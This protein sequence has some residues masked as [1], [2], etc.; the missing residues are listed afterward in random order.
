MFKGL[1]DYSVITNKIDQACGDWP[2]TGNI[3]Y[4]HMSGNEVIYIGYSRNF[5][6]RQREHRIK[7]PWWDEITSIRFV[8]VHKYYKDPFI[9]EKLAIKQFKPKYNVKMND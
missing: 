2:E 3:I 5:I 7:S 1:F 9:L 6:R 4:F 8:R